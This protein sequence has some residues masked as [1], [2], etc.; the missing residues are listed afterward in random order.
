[1]VFLT[2]KVAYVSDDFLI[3]WKKR[4][5]SPKQCMLI[6]SIQLIFRTYDRSHIL[7]GGS[8]NIFFLNHCAFKLESMLFKNV[9]STHV[10]V[11][12]KIVI[13]FGILYC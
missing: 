4:Y 6:D 7:R 9:N 8:L 11:N 2:K 3:Q 5:D 1:M 12:R 13:I 10:D